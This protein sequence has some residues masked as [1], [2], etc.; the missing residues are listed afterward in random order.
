MNKDDTPHIPDKT[1]TEIKT[2]TKSNLKK[3]NKINKT[4]FDLTALKI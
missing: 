2:A 1:I 3:R 4:I